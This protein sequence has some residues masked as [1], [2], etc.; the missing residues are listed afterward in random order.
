MGKN[1]LRRGRQLLGGTV[2]STPAVRT[3]YCV[4]AVEPFLDSKKPSPAYLT[5]PLSMPPRHAQFSKGQIP[6]RPTREGPLSVR[7]LFSAKGL[8]L[9]LRKDFRIGKGVKN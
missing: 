1:R 8:G 3:V 4:R 9:L 2:G 5:R 7:K 6:Y